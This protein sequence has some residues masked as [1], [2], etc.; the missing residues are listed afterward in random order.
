MAARQ[1]LDVN[2]QSARRKPAKTA[3]PR[4]LDADAWA[5]GALAALA[6]G[7][8][9]TVRVAVLAEGLGVTKGSFYWHFKDRDALL[10]KMLERWRRRATLGLIERLDAAGANAEDRLRRL[11]RLPIKGKKSAFGAQVELAIRLWARSDERAQAALAEVDEIRLRY[12][13]KLL[14]EIGAPVLEARARAVLAYSYLRVA[15]SLIPAD[16]AAMMQR[17]ENLII[18]PGANG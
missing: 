16:A 10:A 3:E 15:A 13:T 18:G 5:D 12:I 7:G 14:T 11:L 2:S 4:T 17:C 1:V 6:I 8:I 9:E